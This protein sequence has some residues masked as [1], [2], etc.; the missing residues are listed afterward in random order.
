MKVKVNEID[1]KVKQFPKLMK[2]SV[3]GIFLFLSET[4]MVDFTHDITYQEYD[5]NLSEF[6]DFEGTIELSN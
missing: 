1:K 5:Y 3:G 6:T 4:E 2:D